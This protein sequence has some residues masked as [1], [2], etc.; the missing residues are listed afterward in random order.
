MII[1]KIQFA[2][3]FKSHI[4][5]II[6]LALFFTVSSLFWTTDT[7]RS[8]AD[9]DNLSFGWPVSFVEQNFSRLSP[10]AWFFPHDYG[11][12]LPQEYSS[13]LSWEALLFSWS[14]NAMWLLFV[15]FLLYTTFH[16]TQRFFRFLSIPWILG[17]FVVLLLCSIIFL[18][19]IHYTNKPP[20]VYSI[21]PEVQ[22]PSDINPERL[23]VLF[24]DNDNFIIGDIDP[25]ERTFAE[26]HAYIKQYNYDDTI[27]WYVVN[28]RGQLPYTEPSNVA[29]ALIMEIDDKTAF[30]VTGSD[31]QNPPESSSVFLRVYDKKINEPTQAL[32]ALSSN[33]KVLST[34]TTPINK[35][36]YNKY[37]IGYVSNLNGLFIACSLNGNLVVL[38]QNDEIVN[39]SKEFRCSRNRAVRTLSQDGTTV[40]YT[41]GLYEAYGLGEEDLRRLRNE[42][43]KL[44]AFSFTTSTSTIVAEEGGWL[45][46][47]SGKINTTSNI[48]SQPIRKKALDNAEYTRGFT[49]YQLT[50]STFDFLTYEEVSRLPEMS[51]FNLGEKW[52]IDEFLFTPNG[53]TMV[54]GARSTVQESAR[55]EVFGFYDIYEDKLIFPISITGDNDSARLWQ[56]PD[57]DNAFIITTQRGENREESGGE[58]AMYIAGLYH[59]H[60][61][62]ILKFIDSI[63]NLDGTISLLEN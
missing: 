19:T 60:R 36:Y 35:N 12:G 5:A 42:S 58:T 38:D 23:E 31:F 17:T 4:W 8:H 13:M 33:G 55:E 44:R 6:L 29:G 61:D 59:I 3:F 40:F 41:E 16:K 1:S 20:K 22:L 32:I 39:Q 45:L 54:F 53:E 7:V 28:Q 50:V 18:V 57:K 25:L 2:T 51:S 9:L 26:D 52:H 14:I 30:I 49:F 56:A 34:Q 37:D 11:F 47:N 21:P 46:Y 48:Y 27:L 63:P 15:F 10:P 43:K 62:G 24:K